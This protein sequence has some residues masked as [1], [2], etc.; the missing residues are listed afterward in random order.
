MFAVILSLSVIH[1]YTNTQ[2][3]GIQVQWQ[4]WFYLLY[5][6]GCRLLRQNATRFLL[7][8][9]YRNPGPVQFDGPGADAKAVTLC[10]ED[11]DYMGRIKELQK[12]LDEVLK[13]CYFFVLYVLI[14]V[15]V[16]ARDISF[17]FSSF[18][19][20]LWC[21]C[22]CN[23]GFHLVFPCFFSFSNLFPRF[24]PLWNQVVHKRYWKQLWVLWLLW[25]KFSQQYLHLEARQH[26]KTKLADY[27]L[28]SSL[29]Q[30]SWLC[31][32]S[33]S[34]AKPFTVYW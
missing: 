31:L 34:F 33:S 20:A 23:C 7:D 14:Y 4:L 21:V 32:L 27:A 1:K 26:F 18:I 28:L 13:S 12:Y 24:E 22:S 2:T 17:K 8:D 9:L 29:R 15:C 5:G 6:L 10:V 25:R 30:L 11:R 16:R 3:M 19:W